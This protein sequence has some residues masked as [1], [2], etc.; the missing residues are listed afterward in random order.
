ME[1]QHRLTRMETVQHYEFQIIRSRLDNIESRLEEGE[2][3]R[4]HHPLGE[5]LTGTAILKVLL[6]IILPLLVL[7][8]T[9]DPKQAASAAKLL[10]F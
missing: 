9:G 7:L 6:A 2:H 8:A 3:S 4:H 5:A 1:W 10:P